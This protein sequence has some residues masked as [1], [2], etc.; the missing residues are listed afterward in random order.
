MNFKAKMSRVET[1]HIT[2][3]FNLLDSCIDK[4][5][6]NL[7]AA[8]SYISSNIHQ[9]N[10]KVLRLKYQIVAGFVANSGCS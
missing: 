9:Q 1:H 2:I 5:L 10:I 4:V 7:C 8:Q 3:L 6:L